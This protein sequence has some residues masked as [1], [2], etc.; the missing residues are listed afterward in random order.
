RRPPRHRGEQREG[1]RLPG[2]DAAL[3]G[4]PRSRPG[5]PL[6]SPSRK[7]TVPGRPLHRNPLLPRLLRC[8]GGWNEGCC[9]HRQPVSVQNKEWEM[10]RTISRVVLAAAVV[11][12]LAGPVAALP[13]TFTGSSG[14]LAA[15]ATFDDSVAGTLKVTLTNTSSADVLVPANVLTAVFFS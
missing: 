14:S 15:S 6:Y 3:K 8:P 7:L 4:R 9:L 10:T 1:R 2:A 13:V 12:F 11:M 5:Q